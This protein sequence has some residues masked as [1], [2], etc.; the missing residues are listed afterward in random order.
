RGA[1]PAAVRTC[2]RQARALPRRCVDGVELPGHALPRGRTALRGGGRATRGADPADGAHDRERLRADGADRAWRLGDG[3]PPRRGAGRH[4]AQT[5]LRRTRGGD[6]PVI[7][8]RTIAGLD[9]RRDGTVGLVPTMGG[10]H[11]GHEALFAA[12]RPEC[13]VLVASLFLNPA[14]F[15]ENGD[16]AS[17]PSDFDSDA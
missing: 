6:A 8:E 5:A 2:G 15:S 1:R 9:L 3:R 13:D 12:A 7:V 16:L 14:Q 4:R 17:Y 11:A 10:L